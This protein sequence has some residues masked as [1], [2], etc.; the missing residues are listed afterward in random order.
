MKSYV[1]TLIALVILAGLW[2]FSVYYGK[3]QSKQPPS[4]ETKPPEKL[5]AL[6]SKSIQS[7]TVKSRDG[8]SFTCARQGDKWAITA[9]HPLP[10]DQNAIST[11]LDNLTDASI[12]SVVDEH[13]SNLKDFGLDPPADSIQIQT[14]GKPGQASV[15]LGD[16]TPTGGGLY[17]QLAGNP[18]VVVL[19]SYLKS[20]LEKTLFDMRDKRAVT[21]DVDQLRRIE[22]E[23]KG[24]HWTVEKNP[25]GVWDLVL[26]P[27]VRADPGTVDGLISQLRNATMQKIVAED[28][29]K[30][31]AYGFGSPTLTLKLTGSG[32]TQTLVLGQKGKDKDSSNY[33]AMNSA[34][35]PVF[36]LGS[37]FL[38]QF[39]KDPA[40]LRDKDLFSFATF[41][42]KHLDIQTPKGHWVF[43]RQQEKWK[44]VSPKAK[45]EP[46][47]KMETLLDAIRG[48]RAD[49]FPKARG[50]ALAA[51]GLDKPAY[52]FQVQFGDKNQTETVEVAKLGDH[53]YARRSTDT[54]PSELAKGAL[55]SLEKALGDL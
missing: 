36:M 18:R 38:T 16:E 52:R 50:Q 45:D 2:G 24:K 19:P 8:E 22:V 48:L 53:L 30:A 34:L 26:P 12:D 35:D 41:D 33:Y 27:P 40:D 11:Y 5:L 4:S 7:F 46:S 20:S 17:A 42:A 6:E 23:S 44:Q 13:P 55:D 51:F 54:L 15:L 10:A 43:D 1:K 14:S 25:E 9:P 28:K 21:L 47:D 3:R 39:Q 37:D 29:Q 49:S 31:G 32:G